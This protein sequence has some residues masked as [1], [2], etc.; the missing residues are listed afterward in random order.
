VSRHRNYTRQ[1]GTSLWVRAITQSVS[2]ARANGT[3]VRQNVVGLGVQLILLG[4]A[5]QDPACWEVLC[6]VIRASMLAWSSHQAIL[7][8]A[9]LMLQ[10]TMDTVFAPRS[11]SECGALRHQSAGAHASQQLEQRFDLAVADGSLRR[12]RSGSCPSRQIR[13]T[14]AD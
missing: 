1:S 13:F 10:L 7:L 3:I 6:V 8:V 9:A 12:K 14:A 11:N 5:Q 4:D 2:L